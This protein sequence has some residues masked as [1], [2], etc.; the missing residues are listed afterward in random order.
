M[1]RHIRGT[2][3]GAL[4]GSSFLHAK[5][6]ALWLHADDENGEYECQDASVCV[7]VHHHFF[8]HLT[9]ICAERTVETHLVVDIVISFLSSGKM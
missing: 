4:F 1:P 2:I 5:S 7:C 6:L 8:P 3:G 9:E